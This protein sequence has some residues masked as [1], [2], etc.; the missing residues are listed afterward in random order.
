MARLVVVLEVDNDPLTTDPHEPT[1]H[2]LGVYDD[3]RKV[4]QDAT[5]ITLISAEWGV[6]P[7]RK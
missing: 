6:W 2:L 7:W 1:E 3:H 5:A 4:N